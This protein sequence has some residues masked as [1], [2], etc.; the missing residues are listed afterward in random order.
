MTNETQA[1]PKRPTRKQAVILLG[2]GTVLGIGGCTAWMHYE[3]TNL[4]GAPGPWMTF[5]D[6]AS[7]VSLIGVAL[8]SLGSFLLISQWAQA[9]RKHDDQTL[10]EAALTVW[11]GIAIGT[12]GVVPLLGSKSNLL[13][14]FLVFGIT[15]WASLVGAGM[16][17]IGIGLF[18]VRLGS[19]L[20][21]TLRGK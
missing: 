18:I 15:L 4:W 13:D 1:G 7:V 9:N 10:R 17:L 20:A 6:V 11:A 16:F 5:R 14:N 19:L 3:F 8:S 2:A 21:Q 12:V